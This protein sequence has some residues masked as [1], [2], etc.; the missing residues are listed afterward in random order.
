[1]EETGASQMSL[2]DADARLMKNKN[3]FIVAYQKENGL[4]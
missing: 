4:F 2:T 1:M 3:G